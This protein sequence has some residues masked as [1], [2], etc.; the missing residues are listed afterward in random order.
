VAVTTTVVLALTAG[1]LPSGLAPTVAPRAA[2]IAVVGPTGALLTVAADGS[3]PRHYP[4]SGG[5]FRFPAW[6]PDGTRVAAIGLDA[7]GAGV[8]VIAD[9]DDPAADLVPTAIY[10]SAD[11]P[12]F[13]LYW[14][15]DGRQLTFLTTEPD[16]LALRAAPV[17]GQGAGGIVRRGAPF[18]WDWSGDARI[19]IHVGGSAADA[20]VGEMDLDGTDVVPAGASPGRFQ[21]P[22]VSTADRYRAYVVT[23]TDPAGEIVIESG[24]DAKR[25]RIP[26][27]GATALGWNHAADELAFIDP[28]TPAALPVG[29]LR[30]VDAATGT[31]RLGLDGQVIAFFWAPDGR[32]IAVLSLPGPDDR[33][34]ASRAGVVF[35]ATGPTAQANTDFL[36]LTVVDAATSSVR[37]QRSVRLSDTFLGQVLPYFDQYAL[38]HRIWSPASDALV[39]PLVGAD[40]VAHITV[41]PADGADPRVIADG[42][43]G[44]WSP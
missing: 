35:A 13:Y 24:S 5:A 17:L 6:S 4:L 40:G 36:R 33:Q 42:E 37:W 38:S 14:S 23:G 28:D 34:V 41:V 44:F 18:Y 8:F 11:R 22:V 29:P 27:R 25:Q 2:R 30:I 21:A 26:V 3:S 20:F 32:S 19:M 12:P 16:G 39:L 10:R 31:V 43:I 15:P 1:A 7:A 9:T